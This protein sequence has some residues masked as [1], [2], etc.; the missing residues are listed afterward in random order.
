MQN[1]EAY[2]KKQIKR[3]SLNK[4]P[5]VLFKFLIRKLNQKL[6][7]VKISKKLNRNVKNI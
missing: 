3:F 6:P 5:K 2:N 1:Y 7:N 4:L